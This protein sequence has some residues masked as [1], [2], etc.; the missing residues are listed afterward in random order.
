MLSLIVDDDRFNL[1]YIITGYWVVHLIISLLLL[2]NAKPKWN[3]YELFCWQIDFKTFRNFFWW[4]S[5]WSVLS[6]RNPLHK[7][8]HL[9]CC[10]ALLRGRF[11]LVLGALQLNKHIR[12]QVLR[13][14]RKFAFCSV[15][16]GD[17]RVRMN[18]FLGL[19]FKQENSDKIKTKHRISKDSPTLDDWHK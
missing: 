15:P 17:G 9:L 14:I 2:S 18:I 3:I 19:F 10:R 1:I 12:K 13:Y 16:H 6:V 5:G 4:H 7:I 8:L 11:D